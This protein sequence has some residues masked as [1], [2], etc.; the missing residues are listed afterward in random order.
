MGSVFGG[1][2]QDT[3][4]S[5]ALRAE[6]EAERKAEE[7]RAAALQAAE[8]KR[9]SKIARGIIGSRSLFGQAGGRGF[10]G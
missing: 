4:A 9:K 2:K 10:F 8:E 3:S 6:M 1:Q 5:D 7:E